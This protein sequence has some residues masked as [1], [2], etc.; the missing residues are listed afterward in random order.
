MST[1]RMSTDMLADRTYDE[2]VIATTAI[3]RSLGTDYFGLR[4]ELTEAELIG[5]LQTHI[6]RYKVPRAVEFI[7]ELPRTAT[8]KPQKF[9]LREKEWAGHSSR[10]QG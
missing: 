4:D 9:A 5:Y 6:A 2:D 10:I 3:G 1:D 7:D 8:G